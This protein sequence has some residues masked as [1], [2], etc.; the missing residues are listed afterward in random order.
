MR[1]RARRRVA[2]T[3]APYYAEHRVA[4]IVMSTLIWRG[5]ERLR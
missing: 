5:N 4:D 2:G 3:S 1:G